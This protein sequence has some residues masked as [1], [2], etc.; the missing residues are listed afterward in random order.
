MKKGYKK[1]LIFQAILMVVLLLNSLGVNILVK[2]G[3]IVLLIATLFCFKKFFGFEKTHQRYSKDIIMEVI[4]F[5]I[6]YFILYYILGLLVGFIKIKNYYNFVGL[7]DYILPAI[8]LTIFREILRYMMLKKS[9][10]SLLLNIT[11]CILFIFL[12]ISNAIYSYSFDSLYEIFIF[13]ALILLPAISRNVIFTL[14]TVH[15]GYKPIILYMIVMELFV[16]LIPIIPNP[17]QYLLSIIRVILP[18]ALGYKIY[19]FYQKG[20]DKEITRDYNKKHFAYYIFPTII[21]IVLVY[22]TSGYFHY[23]AIVIGSG[24]MVPE[25]N[26]GDVVVIE[27]LDKQYEK[28]QV[29]QVLAYRYN[30]VII[31]H[32]IVRIV[33]ISDHY[34]FYTKGD[35]NNDEDGIAVDE[36]MVIGTVN[37]KIPV[38]GYPTIWLNEL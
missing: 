4:I 5:L 1:L 6:L 3:M 27:K 17:N 10:G 15:T 33:K 35:K 13:L 30:N 24:S 23:H 25:I 12:D 26:V 7:K 8:L 22:F 36:E 2:Y 14:M 34:Y 16:Y 20:A 18:I 29:G 32:R 19:M 38:I 21:V 31:V 37:W 28:L 11:T 9:E